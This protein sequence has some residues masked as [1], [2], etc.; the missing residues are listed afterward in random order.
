MFYSN[1]RKQLYLFTA[2]HSVALGD[3]FTRKDTDIDSWE[4]LRGKKVVVQKDDIVHEFLKG[5]DMDIESIAV[6]TVG[7]HLDPDLVDL[8]VD[9]ESAH[10]QTS[11]ET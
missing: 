9:I 10:S 3:I 5:K 4:E 2:K 11:I 8:F 1:D 7:Y 6:D